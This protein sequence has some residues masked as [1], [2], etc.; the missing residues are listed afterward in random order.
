M[1]VAHQQGVEVLERH[2]I[3]AQICDEPPEIHFQLISGV[4]PSLILQFLNAGVG[5]S[6]ET[7]TFPGSFM[8]GEGNGYCLYIL[9]IVVIH[10]LL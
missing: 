6:D 4:I 5:L 1:V 2:F 9:L 7:K 8:A 10:F 3:L